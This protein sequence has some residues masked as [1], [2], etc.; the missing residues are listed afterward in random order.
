MTTSQP[1]TCV[2]RWQ[3]GGSKQALVP[4]SVRGTVPGDP[5]AQKPLPPETTTVSTDPVV[6]LSEDPVRGEHRCKAKVHPPLS[7]HC[8]Q[9]PLLIPVCL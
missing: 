6:T 5:W 8:K 4:I 9:K 3:V 1:A 2:W 7:P